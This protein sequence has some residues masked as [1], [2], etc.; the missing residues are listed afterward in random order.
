MGLK[1]SVLDQSPIHDD[2]KPSEAL[3]D[4]IEIAKKSEQ[5]GYHRYWVAEHHDTPGYASATP[6]IMV[7][8]VASAT[9]TIRVG[10]GGVMLNHYSPY[11]VAETFAALHALHVNRIDLGIGRASGANFLSS[12]ALHNANSGDYE[13]KA[14]YLKSFLEG[15]LAKDDY[16]HG[17]NVSPKSDTSPP[18]FLLGSSDG[19]SEL[20]GVLG[21]G[22]CLALFI[23]THDREVSIMQKYRSNFQPSKNF[24]KPKSMIAVAC[25]CAD[26]K[27]E[28]QS[29]ASSHTYWKVQAFRQPVR[30]GLKSP[31]EVAKLYEKLSDED[32]NYYHETMDT[33]VL[34]TPKECKEQIENLAHTYGVDEVIIVNVTYSFKQRVRSYE[35]LAEEF[36][37]VRN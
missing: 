24:A 35:L 18:I 23:G 11:K 34:G 10:S 12:R 9:K 19:S 30:E 25:I 27:E 20:A 28:A 1:L 17:I 4:T 32:K 37:L 33:M 7:S 6:E 16:F 22:F 31:D 36:E 2:K 21:C 29:I 3:H 26:T 13:G 5:W 8:A 14:Y 15:T